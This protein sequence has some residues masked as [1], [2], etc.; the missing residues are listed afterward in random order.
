MQYPDRR[1]GTLR[2]LGVRSENVLI[3]FILISVPPAFQKQA[4]Y[5]VGFPIFWGI[6]PCSQTKFQRRLRGRISEAINLPEA[7]SKLCL[8][9]SKVHGVLSQKT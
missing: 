9:F 2:A 7:G 4:T 5:S 8:I 6:T 3:H 1:R